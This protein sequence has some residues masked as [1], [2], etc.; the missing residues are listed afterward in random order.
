MQVRCEWS[1]YLSSKQ[2]EF[3]AGSSPVTCTNMAKSI[4]LTQEQAIAKYED[5]IKVLEDKIKSK[6]ITK[7]YHELYKKLI[8]QYKEKIKNIKKGL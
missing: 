1:A 5:Q 3:I 6:L 8:K 2:K 7:D 4:E